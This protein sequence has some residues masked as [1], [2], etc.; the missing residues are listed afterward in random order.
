MTQMKTFKRLDVSVQ[1]PGICQQADTRWPFNAS[2]CILI[3]KE[4]P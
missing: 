1:D 4:A 3:Q 2:T